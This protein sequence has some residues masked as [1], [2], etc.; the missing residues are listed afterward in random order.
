MSDHS[1]LVEAFN[2]EMASE[3]EMGH[4]ASEGS[5]RPFSVIDEHIL[6]QPPRSPL[7]SDESD[8]QNSPVIKIPAK[9]RKKTSP[10]VSPVDNPNETSPPCDGWAHQTKGQDWSLVTKDGPSLVK[11]PVLGT[12]RVKELI[13][14]MKTD[15]LTP[16][17][18][19]NQFCIARHIFKCTDFK[20]PDNPPILQ[21][22][23]ILPSKFNIIAQTPIKRG[24]FIMEL[25]YRLSDKV[26]PGV[27]SIQISKELQ[28]HVQFLDEPTKRGSHLGSFIKDERYSRRTKNVDIVVLMTAKYPRVIVLAS[29]DIQVFE[30][31]TTDFLIYN[32]V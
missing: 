25:N 22:A 31:L 23:Q 13:K 21:T 27:R 18:S 26:K 32:T 16:Y 24:S 12:R 3:T 8:G 14:K 20:V 17:S 6:D 10:T 1:R 2:S 9:K 4:Q 19:R 30:P 15:H 11:D 28:Y 7:T 29:R 5:K